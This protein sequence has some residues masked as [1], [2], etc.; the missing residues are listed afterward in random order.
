MWEICTT[1]LP[2]LHRP[3]VI[4]NGSWTQ[5][6]ACTPPLSIHSNSAGKEW[7]VQTQCSTWS[8]S[9]LKHR[10]QILL[11]AIKR[12]PSLFYLIRQAIMPLVYRW[13]K[14]GPCTQSHCR[15]SI[16]RWFCFKPSVL[17]VATL[18]AIGKA[19]VSM[20]FALFYS[21]WAHVAWPSFC[22]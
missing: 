5:T 12:K 15:A 13:C 16:W 3:P 8:K 4:K 6:N 2:D 17:L 22:S 10:T 14:R 7:L 11:A 19:G 21:T 9:G 1:P 20:T 18:L